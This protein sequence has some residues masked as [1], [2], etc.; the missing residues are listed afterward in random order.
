MGFLRIFKTN[1]QN[2]LNLFETVDFTS[3]ESAS[4]I[5]ANIFKNL[6]IET[7]IN[8][9]SGA[10]TKC[11]FLTFEQGKEIKKD[12][13]YS[14]NIEPNYNQNGAK[15]WKE[16]I[17]KLIYQGSCLVVPRTS[18][19]FIADDF[20]REVKGL[21]E[22]EY[23]D[24]KI[25]NFS[26]K[27]ILRESEVLYFELNNKKI[28]SFVDKFY[29]RY[30]SIITNLEEKELKKAYQKYVLYID[31]AYPQ[32]EDAKKNLQNLLNRSF[33]GFFEADKNAVLPLTKTLELK[34]IESQVKEDDKKKRSELIEE[35][36][37]YTALAFG[38]PPKLL[39]GE[40]SD[41]D[42]TVNNLITFCISPIA[43]LISDEINR[44]LYKK[45]KFLDKTYCKLDTTRIKHID[46]SKI[47]NALDVLTRIGV[48]TIND[49]LRTLG[50][51]ELKEDY[52]KD[53]YITKNYEKIEN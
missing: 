47:A 40:V 7:C 9:I 45:Q 17:E 33:K 25:N 29:T 41:T 32:T 26:Y 6:A 18:N 38:I 43:E 14:L 50:K 27:R 51:E 4:D 35:V 48:Y 44:K 13:Y 28:K 20:K 22:A 52:A 46:I 34:P 42:E 5:N 39:L 23:K 21:K 30:N 24:I 37:K 15:F 1:K 53:R 16:V 10:V 3:L 36:F 8:I 49:S 11:E 19:Y 12:I 31:T 2:K